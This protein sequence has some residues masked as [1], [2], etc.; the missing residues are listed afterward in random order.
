MHSL[1]SFQSQLWMMSCTQL[2]STPGL[3]PLQNS[4]MM[5]MTQSHSQFLKLSNDGDIT[6]N[7]LD[8]WSMWS[9]VTGICNIFNNQNPY[10]LTPPSPPPSKPQWNPKWLQSLLHPSTSSKVVFP[11]LWTTPTNLR[12]N[13]NQVTSITN[14][15]TSQ[16]ST[17]F[18]NIVIISLISS[19]FDP[20]LTVPVYTA[21]ICHFHIPITP[22]SWLWS[23]SI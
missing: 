4:T 19:N 16:A 23:L 7:A 8:F 9:L 10:A 11:C 5:S 15:G 18:P 12:P 14:T 13:T 6:S 22:D 2:H 17:L 21:F 1:P 20:V 3:F